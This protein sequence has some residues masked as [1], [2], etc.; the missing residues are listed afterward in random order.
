M[1]EHRERTSGIHNPFSEGPFS[2]PT[3]SDMR[4]LH[5]NLVEDSSLLRKLGFGNKEQ[6][7]GTSHPHLRQNN[8]QDIAQ[9]YAQN[10][11]SGLLNN[12][13]AISVPYYA[14]LGFVDGVFAE[15]GGSNVTACRINSVR[16][17]NNVT[18]LTWY[19]QIR[20]G[21]DKIMLYTTNLA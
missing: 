8:A 2:Q 11:A 15:N 12:T 9:D 21:V 17:G 6:A 14:G 18:L 10:Y 4:K 19:G 5:D 7:Q 16:F 3:V 1:A 20:Y 13:F